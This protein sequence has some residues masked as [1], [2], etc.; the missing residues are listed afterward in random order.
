VGE[1][2]RER[3]RSEERREE[4]KVL[5]GQNELLKNERIELQER[6]RGLEHGE[7]LMQEEAKRERERAEGLEGELERERKERN[8]R[9][10]EL[11]VEKE[12]RRKLEKGVERLQKAQVDAVDTEVVREELRR[13]R[14]FP[15]SAL[16][17][18]ER[19]WLTNDEKGDWNRSS[20][21]SSLYG[22][23]NS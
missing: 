11:E 4:G 13:E 3:E 16:L 6:M 18:K 10:I 5:R 2:G 12:R 22:G 9:G 1:K 21:P 23:G 8:K 14:S 7:F 15:V 19:F 17:F 20:D